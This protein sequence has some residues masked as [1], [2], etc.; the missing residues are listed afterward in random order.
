ME[1]HRLKEAGLLTSAVVT[2]ELGLSATT[3]RRLEG[4][5]FEPVP[6]QGKRQMRVFTSEQ[7]EVLREA[8]WEKTRLGS[9]PELVGLSRWRVG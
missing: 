2:K 8:L 9:K 7:V 5:L 6:R 3:L 4:K 1:T